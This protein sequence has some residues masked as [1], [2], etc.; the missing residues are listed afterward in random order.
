M[1]WLAGIGA[2]AIGA[3]AQHLGHRLAEGAV[4]RGLR[5]HGPGIDAP[6]T[7]STAIVCDDAHAVEQA[8][9][10]H[11]VIASARGPVIRLAPHFY[12]TEAEV[13]HALDALVRVLRG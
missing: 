3:W 8:L 10:G 4:A 1:E 11:G 13:D 2:S 5:L 6:R 12:N 9:L 7:P